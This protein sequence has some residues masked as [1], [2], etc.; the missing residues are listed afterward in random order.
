MK[1]DELQEIARRMTVEALEAYVI[2]EVLRSGLVLGTFFDG[3][4]RIF[5]LYVPGPRPSDAK[6]VVR[7]TL[8]GNTGK[9][10]VEVLG[11]ERKKAL[12]P[13]APNAT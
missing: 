7:V 11:L 5:E 3:S 9:G 8:D 13:Q 2:P 10:E 4:M 6:V 1:L 12:S